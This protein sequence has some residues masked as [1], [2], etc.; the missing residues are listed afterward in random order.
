MIYEFGDFALDTRRCELR[1]A[2]RLEHLEPQVYAVLCHLLEHC[3]R[4]V[5][6]EELLDQV[7]GH[8]FVTPATLNTRIKA[9]RQALGDDGDAQ[10]MI[11]T[12]RGRGF[13][14][15]DNVCTRAEARD[16]GSRIK[17]QESGIGDQGPAIS[18]VPG[19]PEPKQ[20]IRFCTASDGV[21]IA[22][23]TSGAGPPLVKPA[24][25]LTHLEFDWRSPVWRHWLT[26]LGRDH[27]LIR[28]DE[29]GCGLSDHDVAECTFEAWVRDL[30]AV[31]DAQGLE[32]FPLL[33]ISQGCAV[34]IAYAVR[35][36]ERVSRLVLYGGYVVGRNYRSVTPQQQ[37][38]SA[39][40]KN[41]IRVG[42]GR[43]NPAFRQVFGQLFLPEGSPE[44][45]HWFTDLA[46]TLPMENALR[47]MEL[48][49]NIDVRADAARLNLPVLVLHARHDAMC[50]FEAGRVLAAHIPGARFV[51][52]EGHNH[53]LMENE[54]A[55][56]HFVEEV[57][58]FLAADRV[59]AAQARIPATR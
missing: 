49:H 48:T 55:W 3:D 33:G 40:L 9:L 18:P 13:R 34:A 1:R 11:R 21:R 39:L 42:W 32:R 8:R 23:A 27:T 30:E 19:S 26:E 15:V 10:R 52:L 38:E 51:P 4:V 14:F 6:K 28:Y 57:N 43:E 20:Q 36:P 45:H 54:P 12:V 29:R 50:P 35:H 5:T 41:L 59:E 7:W 16:Q 31:V 53:V 2:G 46:T 22:Y 56:A 58:A 24:N 44:Q 17:D 47:I 37:L 25:W